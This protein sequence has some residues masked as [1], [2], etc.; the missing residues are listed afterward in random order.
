M[1]TISTVSVLLLLVLVPVWAM[2]GQVEG[3]IQGFTCVTQGKVCPIDRED[4]LVAATRVFVVNTSGHN[5]YLVPN[6]DRAILARYLNKKVRVVGNVN[7]KYKSIT[8]RSFEVWRN[9]NWKTVWTKEM[10]DKWRKELEVGM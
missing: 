3:T 7:A 10:E 9:G 4:P 1:K 2:A 8:A 5:Y 6:L